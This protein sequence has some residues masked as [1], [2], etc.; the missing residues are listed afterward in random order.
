[1]VAQELPVRVLRVAI[2]Q[3][4]LIKTVLEVVVLVLLEQLI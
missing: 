4:R 3:Q 2:A 1:V